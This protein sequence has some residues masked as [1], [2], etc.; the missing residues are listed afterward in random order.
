MIIE[1]N[2]LVAM[3]EIDA[4]LKVEL[5]KCD[6]REREIIRQTVLCNALFSQNVKRINEDRET[7]AAI[8]MIFAEVMATMPREFMRRKGKDWRNSDEKQIADD[9]IQKIITLTDSQYD[10]IDIRQFINAMR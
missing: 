4:R 6:I 10:Y 7:K 1:N 5:R 9:F 2:N 3:A 8:I